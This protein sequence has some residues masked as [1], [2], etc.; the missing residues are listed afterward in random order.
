MWTNPQFPAEILN[1]KLHFLY[2]DTYSFNFNLKM[3]YIYLFVHKFHQ[4]DNFKINSMIM[5]KA[6]DPDLYYPSHWPTTL[7]LKI[8]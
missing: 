4:K 3:K 6:N 7:T 2:S 8:K 5:T 1:G